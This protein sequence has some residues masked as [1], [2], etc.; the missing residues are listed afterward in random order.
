MIEM[1]KFNFWQ[2]WLFIVS[3]F[4]V[5]F[6][7]FMAFFNQSAIMD[8]FIN[9]Y[10]N[11]A[12]WKNKIPEEASQFQSFIYAV[13]GATICGWGVI[14]AFIVHY[15]F[16]KKERWSWNALTT[17]IIL[18]FLI[19]TSLSAYFNVTYNVILNSVIFLLIVVPLLY[20]KKYFMNKN[21]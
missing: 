17:G 9:D 4:L 5:V 11:P 20:T 14:Q 3:I 13:L 6:G 12:F 2:M 7:L 15:P 10:V 1:K 16:K 18:W 21:S 8:F 19:D